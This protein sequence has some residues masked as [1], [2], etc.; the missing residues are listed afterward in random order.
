[1]MEN[2]GGNLSNTLYMPKSKVLI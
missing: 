2:I 1:M